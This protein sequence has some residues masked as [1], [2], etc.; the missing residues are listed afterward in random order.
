MKKLLRIGNH[1]ISPNSNFTNFCREMNFPIL[2]GNQN[3]IGKK[4]RHEFSNKYFFTANNT[5]FSIKQYLL[6]IKIFISV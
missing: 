3:G 1:N 5:G 2:A 6:Y 4:G